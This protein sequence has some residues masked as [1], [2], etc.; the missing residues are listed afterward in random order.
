MGGTALVL[1]H[2]FPLTSAMWAEQVTGLADL[3]QVVT[4]DQRG[5]GSAPLG[6][7]EPSLDR[8]ADDVAD[9]LDREGLD[10]IVLGGLSMGG[11]VVMAFL[12]R[13]PDRV[14]ALLLADTKATADPPPA[15]EKRLAMAER[16]DRDGTADALVE[17]VLPGLTGPTTASERPDVSNR[18]R[19]MVRAA[20][21]PAAAWAQRAMAARPDS[22]AT[23]GAARVPC[24]V[25]RGDE[26]GLSSAED[27]AAMV[28]AL[29]DGRL[30]TIPGAGHLSNLEAPEE[31]TRAVADFLADVV[32]GPGSR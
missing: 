8:A 6:A 16:L 18:V 2:A 25:V 15:R 4:P 26:D 24:L 30:V 7:D 21:A 11:Y 5:F 1:L 12:R 23:L 9:L 10:D 22:L 31:F 17:H 13:H 20:P 14:R 27:V 32:R 19:A 3:V 29:P 28:D